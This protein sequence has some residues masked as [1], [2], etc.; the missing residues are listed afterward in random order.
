M[1]PKTSKTTPKRATEVAE[2]STI[3]RTF[4]NSRLPTHPRDVPEYINFWSSRRAHLIMI[5]A[6][7]ALLLARHYTFRHLLAARYVTLQQSKYQTALEIVAVMGPPHFMDVCISLAK[8]LIALTIICAPPSLRA[9]IPSLFY[10]VVCRLINTADGAYL[11]MLQLY[12]VKLAE[13]YHDYP[14][15]TKKQTASDPARVPLIPYLAVPGSYLA[16]GLVLARALVFC[17]YECGAFCSKSVPSGRKMEMLA[18]AE[19]VIKTLLFL[20]SLLSATPFLSS[21]WWLTIST[22]TTLLVIL[23]HR[24][25]HKCALNESQVLYLT[26]SVDACLSKLPTI[27]T[28]TWF[29]RGLRKA[30]DSLPKNAY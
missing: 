3:T 8:T 7:D 19:Y 16:S 21:G 22:V 23:Y 14:W 12:Q 28:M 25:V 29:A 17:I 27:L 15:F 24:R 10:L 5:L 9:R 18:S 1:A 6:A 20:N 26:L 2:V 13:D 11:C 4:K 30:A